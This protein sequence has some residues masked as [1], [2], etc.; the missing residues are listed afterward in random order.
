MT[1]LPVVSGND[2]IQVLQKVGYK[3]TR[4]RGSHVRMQCPGRTPVTVPKHYE[5]DRGT[6][7]NIIRTAN[8]TVDQF[9]SL[10]T[11]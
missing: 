5:I 2:C 6:L 3:I 1:S 9:I 10:L 11:Q 8:I 7:S 4:T